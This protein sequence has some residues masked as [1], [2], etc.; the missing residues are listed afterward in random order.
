VKHRTFALPAGNRGPS[1]FFRIWM[2]WN[3]ALYPRPSMDDLYL[4]RDTQGQFSEEI[5]ERKHRASQV[6][7]YASGGPLYVCWPL[8]NKVRGNSTGGR[9]RS[10]STHCSPVGAF[11]S[12]YCAL[13]SEGLR[14]SQHSSS[15]ALSPEVEH[16]SVG[17][18]CSF[19]VSA[20]PLCTTISLVPGK[21]LAKSAGFRTRPGFGPAI[22]WSAVP[23]IPI[24]FHR[25]RFFV[26]A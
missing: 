25:L 11:F 22:I 9:F 15:A 8:A 2:F 12:C 17:K 16:H 20:S 1:L 6:F 23:L 19:L 5:R 18:V 26:A 14:R 10:N 21:A 4:L 13:G 7:L 3:S 24:A